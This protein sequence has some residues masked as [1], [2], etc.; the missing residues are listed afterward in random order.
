MNTRLAYT[1]AEACEAARIGR[2]SIYDAIKSSKLIARKNGRR[3][4]I[5]AEDLR[6]WLQDLPA[7]T[8]QAT[9]KP[10]GIGDHLVTGIA[11]PSE[12][13]PET[14]APGAIQNN[15]LDAR[16]G[17]WAARAR[18]AAVA[19][20]AESKDTETSLGIRL[21]GD[22]K[23]IFEDAEELTSK[24]ILTCLT[25]LP[26]SPWADIRGKPLDERGLS[27]RLRPYGIKPKTIRTGPH[28][29]LRGYRRADFED[30][31]RRLLPPVT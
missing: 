19:L 20:V 28:S 11:Q 27:N 16:A 13:T 14:P 29:T 26:E 31:W 12:S 22:L 30:Q 10:Q 21:L 3:T 2:T 17:S 7:R 8:P 5:L 6:L 25:E 15:S 1:I 9:S 18:R 23:I 4:V 24:I